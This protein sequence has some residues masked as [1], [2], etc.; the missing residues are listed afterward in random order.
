MRYV[1]YLKTERMQ[2]GARTA[3]VAS[4]KRREET[5]QLKELGL[6]WEALIVLVVQ[7]ATKFLAFCEAWRSI[8]T[9][10]TAVRPL[11]IL[12]QL[13]TIMPPHP[14]SLKPVISNLMELSPSWKGANYVATQELPTNLRNPKVH[15]RVHKSPPLVPILSQINPAR[16]TASCLSQ[17]HFTDFLHSMY[18][19]SC[20]FSLAQ[21]IHPKN[22]SSPEAL[23]D[24]S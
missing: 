7:L 17:I 9:C 2:W 19:I 3:P 20:P 11:N 22:P 15:Y 6:S 14:V 5:N 4:E 24:I 10:A 12:S 21:V 18:Q 1:L 16:T 23:C 8:S 13:S